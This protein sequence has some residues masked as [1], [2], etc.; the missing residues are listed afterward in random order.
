VLKTRSRLLK[1]VY[2]VLL[3][4]T[5]LCTW[6][7]ELASQGFSPPEPGGRAPASVAH[8]VAEAR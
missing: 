1:E 3:F 6:G 5:L 4:L 2:P 8:A 7:L